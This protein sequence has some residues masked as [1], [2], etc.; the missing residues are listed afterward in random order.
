MN[1][2][3]LPSI[4]DRTFPKSSF[5]TYNEHI[6]DKIGYDC[7]HT[8]RQE[9]EGYDI[10]HLY[11]DTCHTDYCLNCTRAVHYP[12]KISNNSHHI[13]RWT[14]WQGKQ[15]HGELASARFTI[16]ELDDLFVNYKRK[17]N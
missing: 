14:L 5:Y 2:N 8:G 9:Y 1:R 7:N 12:N 16:N 13:L 15:P 4:L 10:F 6:P 3:S 11:C 17:I